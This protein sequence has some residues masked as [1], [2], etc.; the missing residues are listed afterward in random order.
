MT[1]TTATAATTDHHAVFQMSLPIR[2]GDMDA[3]GHVNNTVYFRYME[4]VRISWLEQL[5]LV[6]SR[7]AGQGPVMVNASMEFLRQL[8]YPGDVIGRMSVAKRGR[9]SFDTRFELVRADDPQTL[10]ARG[11]ARCVWIDYAAG[12][13]VPVPEVLRAAIEQAALAS[14]SHPVALP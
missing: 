2:W 12:K 1:A 3:F 7:E 5:D 6:L 9:S 4:Q 10:Y 8:H 14:P 13:S 11:A